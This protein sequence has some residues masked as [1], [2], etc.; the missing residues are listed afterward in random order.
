MVE[1]EATDSVGDEGAATER[2][3]SLDFD[4]VGLEGG[5][6]GPFCKNEGANIAWR[7]TLFFTILDFLL[8]SDFPK[9]ISEV[10]RLE[11]GC[12]VASDM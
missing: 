11:S 5:D 9:G 1:L 3:R 4:F 2:A 6:S 10:V 7:E 12:P 8:F